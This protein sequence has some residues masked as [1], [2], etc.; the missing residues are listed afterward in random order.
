MYMNDMPVNSSSSSLSDEDKSCCDD[1]CKGKTVDQ[2]RSMGNYLC[3]KAY[4]MQDELCE[5]VTIEDFEKMSKPSDKVYE[6]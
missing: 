2:I 3:D 6:D 4:K 5:K 1:M